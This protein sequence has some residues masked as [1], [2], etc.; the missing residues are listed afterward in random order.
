MLIATR[1]AQIKLE[2]RMSIHILPTILPGE[3]IYGL[4]SRI[5]KINGY[6]SDQETCEKLFGK[7]KQLRVADIAVNFGNFSS[8][9]RNVY[10]EIDNLVRST[11]SLPLFAGLGLYFSSS[12]KQMGTKEPLGLATFSNGYPHL[13][14]WCNCCVEEDIEIYGMP[15]WHRNQQLPGVFICTR[16]KNSLMET[17][18]PFRMRQQ[19]FM[20]PNAL[21]KTLETR[22]TLPTAFNSDMAFNLACFVEHAAESAY[23][24][25]DSAVPLNVIINQLKSRELITKKGKLR[26]PAF[27]KEFH[28]FLENFAYIEDV[29]SLI[30]SR[31]QNHL[32]STHTSTTPSVAL[33]RT[34]LIFW[35]FGNWN[36]FSEYCSWGNVFKMISAQKETEKTRSK[37][38][39][40]T[41]DHYKA[42]IDFLHRNPHAIRSDFW[43]ARPKSCRWLTRNDKAWLE[44]IFNA[45]SWHNGGQLEM[46]RI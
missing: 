13:W 14:R 10:G 26:K 2:L 36:L 9:T 38:V 28:G 45:A 46:F 17:T 27:T 29:A 37:K 6:R 30:N 41:D 16:H 8:A 4:C 23:E 1:R 34:L 31:S 20:H 19:Y 24:F 35:L 7:S 32:G 15:Y 33:R 5:G 40:N 21:P 42:C 22:Q 39:Q 12:Y 44:R 43:R 25:T 18:V 11:T 3:T